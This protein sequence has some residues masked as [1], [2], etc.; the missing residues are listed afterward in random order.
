V[1]CSKGLQILLKEG[2][3]IVSQ[4]GS[5]LKLEKDGRRVIFPNHGSK[6]IPKGTWNA[7]QKQ[8]GLK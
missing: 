5:H 2:W 4:K 6:E 1:K 8:A 7:I 3:K